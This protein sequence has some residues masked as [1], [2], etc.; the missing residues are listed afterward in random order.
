MATTCRADGDCVSDPDDPCEGECRCEGEW[1]NECVC[2]A[3]MSRT[4]RFLCEP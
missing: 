3:N 1:R 4:R 2:V